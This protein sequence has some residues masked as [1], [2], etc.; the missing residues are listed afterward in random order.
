VVRIE[1]RLR[2]TSDD[3]ANG[4]DE[5]DTRDVTE[6]VED[7][8]LQLDDSDDCHSPEPRHRVLFG[9]SPPVQRRESWDQPESTAKMAKTHHPRFR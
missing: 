1:I 3:T 4:E 7:R 2:L 8:W 6:R 9:F 5:E